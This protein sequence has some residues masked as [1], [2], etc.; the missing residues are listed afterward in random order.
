MNA[1]PIV[2]DNRTCE[3][4]PVLAV[5]KP[6][7]H[8]AKKWLQWAAKL[9]HLSDL[10][11]ITSN[12]LT[13]GQVYELKQLAYFF[14][15]EVRVHHP[16]GFVES[17]YFGSANQMFI[18]ALTFCEEYYGDHA[19]LW[20]EADTCPMRSTWFD[21]ICHEWRLCDR[22]FLGDVV[23]HTDIPHMT[24]NGVY[25]PQ[26]RKHAPSLAELPGP[27]LAQ[28]WDS[29]CAK[30]IFPNCAHSKTILQ[31]WRPPAI[32]E[33]WIRENVTT[34]CALFHQCKDGTI[35]DV[36]TDRLQAPRI[37]LEVPLAKSSYPD[38][39]TSP[40]AVSGAL[41][42]V[43]IL[44]VTC[45]RD[46]EFLKYC[47]RGIRDHA[48]GFTAVK[49]VV[50]EHE[51]PAFTWIKQKD[52]QVI[53][54]H[55]T[56]GKGMM[57]HEIEKCMADVHCPAADFILHLD[58]DCIPFRRFTPADYVSNW[59]ALMVREHY[60]RITNSN[61]HIWKNVVKEAI[62]VEPVYDC[63]VRHPQVHPRAVYQATRNAV[64]KWTRQPFAHYVLLCRNE[65]PQGFAEF[66]TISTIGLL[67]MPNSYSPIEYD[68]QSDAELVGQDPC[69]FQYVYRR[70]R[71][72]IVEF[73]SHG[74][75]NRYR[76]DLE[77]IFAGRVPAYW[78]K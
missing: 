25:H 48:S 29:Q 51:R 9:Q 57:A 14:A 61:R 49:V 50:P 69:S 60:S 54:F 66:P 75:I 62:G 68:K 18:S 46:V 34:D 42:R 76:G 39:S 4:V 33:A 8:L 71:N 37:P 7:W 65:F 22:P 45:A 5:C 58:A 13:V 74:G 77:G 35:I 56:P 43:E 64:E 6:D 63:M 16:N 59:R 72:H 23:L 73:W 78:V 38:A 30:D 44:I 19:M 53:Y 55:E 15:S 28:G 11:I 41:P 21:E 52:A 1:E 12:D 10:V 47:L 70:D 24:G 36:L 32:T 17:G 20:I 31:R 26:W 3:V 40:R 27:V 2:T 67:L